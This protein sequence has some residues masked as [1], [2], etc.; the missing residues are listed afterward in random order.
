MLNRHHGAS[1][2]K[3]YDLK[4]AKKQCENTAVCK[5]IT[6]QK[7]NCGGKYRLAL[8]QRPTLVPFSHWRRWR[9][10]TYVL[11]R[12]CWMNSFWSH[13]LKGYYIVESWKTNE[14]YDALTAKYKC[15]I[16]PD[17]YG[18]A[19]QTNN[20][21]GKYRVTH[22]V[23]A[24]LKQ[25]KNWKPYKMWAYTIDRKA[26][27]GACWSARRNG[28]WILEQHGKQNE[29][30]SFAVA[31]QKCLAA[32]DCHG[33]ATQKNFCGGKYRVTH[34]RK[35]TLKYYKDWKRFNLWAYTLDRKCVA[36][37]H[38]AMQHVYHRG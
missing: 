11:N 3:C 19:T 27:L 17:C 38:R 30:Y 2:Q 7:D 32:G 14:C 28:Y 26:W 21:K 6:T 12:S 31:K 1:R 13:Q 36:S 8:T 16:A 9:L 22:G 4:A 20:C 18:I 5:A 29:C 15:M 37:N 23:K 25:Y 34:G 10:Q 24:T 35:A 33:I